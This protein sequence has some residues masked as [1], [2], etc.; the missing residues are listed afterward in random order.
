MQRMEPFVKRLIL[1]LALLSSLPAAAQSDTELVEVVF[2]AAS[3]GAARG[4]LD[5]AAY[6]A[7]Q[8]AAAELASEADSIEAADGTT[9][10]IEVILVRAADGDEALEAYQDAVDD[11]AAAVLASTSS[12]I[13]DALL[14]RANLPI[15]VLYTALDDE[16]PAGALK[17][18]PD[19]QA[20][21]AAAADYLTDE[22]GVESIAVLNADTVD[23]ED[24]ADDF[25]RI[26]GTDTVVLR[27]V[28][29]ADETDFEDVAREVRESGAGAAFIWTLD[30][31]GRTLLRALDEVGWDGLI[32]YMGVD[33]TFMEGAPEPDAFGGLYTPHGWR[34]EAANSATR[35]FLAVMAGAGKA[36]D[37]ESGAYYDMIALVADSLRRTE[38]VTRTS[39]GGA[40]LEG[41]QGEYVN[42]RP[43]HVLLFQTEVVPE[44]G[45]RLWE[46]ARYVSGACLT[47]PDTFVSDTTETDAARDALFT[48][49]LL[50][51]QTGMTAETGRHAQQAME[52]AIREINDSGGVIGPQNVRYALRLTTYNVPDPTSAPA[53]FQQALAQGANVILGPDANSAVVPTALAADISGIPQIS[54]A[55]GLTSAS[56]NTVQYLKQG[57]SND[58]TRAR[59]AVTFVT[60]EREQTAIALIVARTDW[61]LNV[62]SAVRESIR[63]TDEGELVLSLEHGTEQPDLS[64]FY[65]Q[66]AESGAEAI[67]VWSIP[68]SLIS[69]LDA[70]EAH[71]WQGTVVYGYAIP[72][73]LDA[74]NI[75]VPPNIDLLIPVGWWP[76]TTHWAGREFAQDYTT[77]FDEQPIEQTAAYYDAVHLVR[78][79][80]EAVGPAPAALRD[81][82]SEDA[83]FYGAQGEYQP[84]E[85]GTG[86]LT[87]AV[88][89]LSIGEQLGIAPVARYVRCSDLC[90]RAD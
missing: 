41:A 78:R 14:D 47:C 35:E 66:I 59:A 18:T 80:L 43:T 15:P 38:T 28:H 85:Y 67:L 65:D 26:V 61:G 58:Q 34:P 21:I 9:Y 44:S 48:I 39:L 25:E 56:L 2:I 50:A 51:D 54:T 83:L 89:I 76:T 53:A 72:E 63:S 29:A 30:A 60:E 31:P 3:G 37:A 40:N 19:L 88:Q 7:A 27:A 52:L 68:S 62:Q 12:V 17:L 42:G 64:V 36:A 8:A 23:A 79:A 22:R 71:G 90:E 49:A 45:Y 1:L 32:V 73:L 4:T 86:E 46:A 87:Q 74:T 55:T 13:Q 82:L 81:Y 70:L 24:G 10:E 84:A 6:S 16:N 33:D 20:Q 11:G 77:L 57:R 69:L 75:P 5:D